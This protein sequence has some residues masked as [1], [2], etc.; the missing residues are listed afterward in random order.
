MAV[1]TVLVVDDSA[2]DRRLAGGLLEKQL[3]CNVRYAA[4]GKTALADMGQLLPDMVVT[5][6]QMPEM[7]GLE[8]VAA[9]KNDYPYIPVVLMT[10]QGSEEIAAQ[11][12]RDGAASY[13]PKRRLKEDLAAT[14][15]NILLGSFEDR[16]HSQ[17]MHYL[18]T[19]EATFVLTNDPAVMQAL[20]YHLQQVLRCLPLADEAERLRVGVALSEALANACYHGN[21]EVKGIQAQADRQSYEQLAQQRRMESP[22]RDR[23]IQVTAR[24]SRSAAVFVIRDDGPGFD[25]RS[26]IAPS[27]LPDADAAEGR[28]LTLMRSIMDDVTFNERGNEVTM[29]KRRAQAPP[30][31]PVA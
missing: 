1:L 26:L 5:D 15:R 23:R 18:E 30:S 19:S 7:N 2:V 24:V 31:E 28:G 22:Y 27:S 8:L 13:V 9:V 3:E 16:T 12:L 11:A 25:V 20:V 29:I 14:V 6:L 4:D 17:L 21:L 10:S